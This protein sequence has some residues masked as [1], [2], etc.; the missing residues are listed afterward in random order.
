[1]PI[2]VFLLTVFYSFSVFAQNPAQDAQW[3]ALLHY[4]KQII[5]AD[6]STIDSENFFLSPV[7]K[8][9][10]EAELAATIRLF[11][12][13]NDNQKKCLFPARYK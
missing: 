11:E 8:Y 3:L 13:T 12:D 5:S 7:G 4:Q 6:E 1:M 2:V 10:P 9:N